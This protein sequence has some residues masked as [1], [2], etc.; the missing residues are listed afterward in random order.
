MGETVNDDAEIRA[1]MA[2]K[3]PASVGTVFRLCFDMA[4]KLNKMF[5]ILSTRIDKLEARA[6][7]SL[8]YRGVW[9]AAENY[10][11]GDAVTRDGSLWIATR[12]TRDKPAGPD[13]GWQMCVKR[14]GDRG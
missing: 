13:T 1:L 9:Q 7:K 3:G 5:E 11:E 10:Q 2:H 8:K 12:G 14:G 6:E 4:G